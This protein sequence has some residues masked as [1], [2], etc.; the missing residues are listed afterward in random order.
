MP[1]RDCGFQSQTAFCHRQ[2]GVKRPLCLAF[3]ALLTV[4][5]P[6]RGDEEPE[7]PPIVPVPQSLSRLEGFQLQPGDQPL[8][9]LEQVHPTTEQDRRRRDALAR[10]LSGRILQER[11]EFDKALEAYLNAIQLDPRAMDAYG[12]ALP[13]LL[14]RN[15]FDEA[16]DLCLSAARIDADSHE[17]IIALGAVLVRQN[18]LQEGVTLLEEAVELPSLANKPTVTLNLRKNLGLYYRLDNQLSKAAEQYEIVFRAIRSGELDKSVQE[19][20]AEN[21]GALFDEF[22]EVFLNA[23]KPELALE[24]FDAASEYREAKP[25]LHSYNLAMVFRKTGK[26]EQALEELQKYFD[27]QL[28]NRGR[29]AYSLLK[30]LL[31]E[32]KRSDELLPRL[33]TMREADPHNDVLRYFVADELLAQEQFSEAEELYRNGQKTPNDP[34]AMIGLFT[35]ALQNKESGEAL[36]LLTKLLQTVPRA[37]EEES[38]KRMSPDVRNLAERLEAQLDVLKENDNV[39]QGIIEEARELAKGDEPKIEFFQAYVIG[40]LAVESERTEFAKEFYRLAISMRNDPPALL[41]SELASHLVD[42]EEFQEAITVLTEALEHPSGQLQREHWR[43]LFL[44]SYAQEFAGNTEEAITTIH[45]AQGLQPSISR[46]FYQEAWIVYHARK[47]KEALRLFEDV[48]RNYS[49]D[50]DLVQDCKFRIS[51]IYVEMGETE[52]GEKVL[53]E[54]LQDDPNNIQANNDLGYLWADQGKN[55]ERAKKMIKLALDAEPEN[56]AYLDSLGW[57]EF[58]LKNYEA[59]VEHLRKATT[60]KNGDDSTIQDHLGDALKEA[61][62]VDEARAAWQ[63]ALEI[64]QAKSSP[65]EELL[66]KI[67]AKLQ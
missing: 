50:R 34:R 40:K 3:V 47:W 4:S 26:S 54:V 55:L 58:K 38:L 33:K 21:A 43:F 17:L 16:R 25:G 15:R 32:L 18:R 67:R 62:Q 20:V 12:S 45:Q 27:A 6:L 11:G 2:V 13:I 19:K 9:T 31:A 42:A 29:E 65:N 14:Q 48:V 59:A 22:G 61:G 41:Y 8:S 57:V 46:L 39:F 56:P 66:E 5:L 64:E 23:E 51:N 1:V 30:E 63:K 24:A 7:R 37:E 35:I 44:L 10:Y 53:E 36:T 52:Q 28:Q 60:V 49:G